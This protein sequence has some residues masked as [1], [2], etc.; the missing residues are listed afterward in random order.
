MPPAAG[1]GAAHPDQSSDP[2]QMGES[3]IIPHPQEESREFPSLAPSEPSGSR[4]LGF[5]YQRYCCE[6]AWEVPFSGK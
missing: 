5:C 2:S 4:D 3:G 1:F 6:A